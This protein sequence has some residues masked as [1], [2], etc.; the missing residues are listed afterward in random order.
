MIQIWRINNKDTGIFG[1]V[2]IYVSEGASDDVDAGVYEYSSRFQTADSSRQPPTES[3]GFELITETDDFAEARYIALEE[4]TNAHVLF[5]AH[6]NDRMPLA[7]IA[8]T[9]VFYVLVLF[10]PGVI[11]V[12][13]MYAALA[14]VGVVVSATMNNAPYLM[15]ATRVSTAVAVGNVLLSLLVWQSAYSVMDQVAAAY[16][17]A[18]VAVIMFAMVCTNEYLARAADRLKDKYE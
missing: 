10:S 12:G 6:V 14:Q 13:S 18:V 9:Q 5:D 8:F 2:I 17:S 11:Y 7:W 4:Q 3:M 1:N 15:T 16:R